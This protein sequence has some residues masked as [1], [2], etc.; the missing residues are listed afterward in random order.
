MGTILFTGMGYK[1]CRLSQVGIGAWY[2][3][4]HLGNFIIVHVFYVCLYIHG[5]IHVHLK[6]FKV[7]NHDSAL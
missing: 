6:T 2:T 3:L 5:Y 1:G 4:E 7:N